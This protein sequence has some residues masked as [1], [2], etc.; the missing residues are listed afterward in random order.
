MIFPIKIKPLKDFTGS[1]SFGA[2]RWFDKDKDGIRERN[3]IRLHAGID[4]HSKEGTEVFAMESGKI[5]QFSPEYYLGTQALAIKGKNYTIRYCEIETKLRAGKEVKEGDLIGTVK[6]CKGIPSIM[7]HVELFTM[8]NSN[9]P[10]TNLN[11]APYFRR[12]DLINPTN[13]LE[14]LLKEM[15]IKK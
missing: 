11:N 1:R 8:I 9:F 7:L 2:E 5:W 15:L 6:R 4:L 13:L 3:E 12:S 14:Q 10:L